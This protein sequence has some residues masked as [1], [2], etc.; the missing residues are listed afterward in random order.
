MNTRVPAHAGYADRPDAVEYRT[1]Y[2]VSQSLIVQDKLA[3]RIRQVIAL[4][5]ITRSVEWAISELTS[6]QE[7]MGSSTCY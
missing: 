2:A 6:L 5:P 3:K 1:A 4:V 7:E